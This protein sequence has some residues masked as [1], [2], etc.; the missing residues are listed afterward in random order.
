MNTRKWMA[1]ALLGAASVGAQ[2]DGIWIYEIAGSGT[3]IPGGTQGCDPTTQTCDFD[4][5]WSGW[6]IVQTTNDIYDGTASGADI[7]NV[8]VSTNYPSLQ[9]DGVGTG[10]VFPSDATLTIAD[11]EIAS[12]EFDYWPEPWADFRVSGTSVSWSNYEGDHAEDIHLSG[13]LVPIVINP[14]AVP[15]PAT[16]A[17]LLL[18]LGVI[19]PRLRRQRR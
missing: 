3:D 12:F 15:E 9:S 10:S 19:A 8:Q 13:S 4:V 16:P 18:G 5:S 17:L 7:T 14:G 2:A 6:L 1:A 11:H